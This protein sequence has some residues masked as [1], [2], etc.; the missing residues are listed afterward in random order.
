MENEQIQ[1]KHTIYAKCFICLTS[2]SKLG[3]ITH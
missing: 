1:L 2:I 3:E